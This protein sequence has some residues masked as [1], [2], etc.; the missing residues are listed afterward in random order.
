[1]TVD[2]YAR[3]GSARP[4]K[5]A[6]TTIEILLLGLSAWILFGA[7]RGLV[8]GLL[9]WT[10]PPTIPARAHLIFAFSVVIMA[11]MSVT[12]FWLMKRHMGWAEV[13][14]IPIA[15]AL[16]Y[17]G[18]AIFVLPQDAPLGGWDYFAVVLFALGC[19]LNTG[20]ELARDQFKKQPFN[21]GKLYTGGLFSLS[22]HINFF[23]DILWVSA[24]AVVAH[25]IWAGIVP[26]FT[27]CFFGF[28][29]APALDRHLASHYGEQ[30]RAYAARTKMLIPLIW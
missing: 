3:K 17:V 9:G 15:F 19:Y 1:M 28:F 20:S 5:V 22:R 25:T 29:N 23:G 21:R 12:L 24:Y 27:L 11:R 8:A 13:F 2:I 10:I 6:L 30:Y 14:T 4:Q 26:V 7:G 18:F 16:Y